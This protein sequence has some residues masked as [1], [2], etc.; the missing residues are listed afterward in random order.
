MRAIAPP[1]KGSI[2]HAAAQSDPPV[3]PMLRV[4]GVLVNGDKIVST[5]T[6]TP[7][8]HEAV[9]WWHVALPWLSP[10]R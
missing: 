1:A 10:V 7:R 6:T 8:E 4:D 3:P 2:R 9:W 5:R